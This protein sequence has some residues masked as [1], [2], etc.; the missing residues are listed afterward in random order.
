MMPM[1]ICSIQDAAR[2]NFEEGEK[3]VRQMPDAQADLLL[4]F[5]SPRMTDV[6]R[7][8]PEFFEVRSLD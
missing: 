6:F 7:D 2:K 1:Q 3:V 8:V 5:T 4:S